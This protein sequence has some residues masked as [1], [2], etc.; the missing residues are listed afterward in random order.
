MVPCALEYLTGWTR[1]VTLGKTVGLKGKQ[2]DRL[3]KNRKGYPAFVWPSRL[4]NEGM[5]MDAGLTALTDDADPS[6]SHLPD[7]RTR[8]TRPATEPKGDG[9]PWHE[10]NDSERRSLLTQMRSKWN[11]EKSLDELADL[12]TAN[13]VPW[14][15]PRI[16][17]HR[18]A[19]MSKHSKKQL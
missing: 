14:E 2:L 10:M 8:N 7:G 13:S 5:L 3:T 1:W 19:G 4:S 11:W 9:V 18:G 6:I 12:A 17:G 15:V 16:I